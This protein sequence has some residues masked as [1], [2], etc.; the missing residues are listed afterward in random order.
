MENAIRI[1]EPTLAA[2]CLPGLETLEAGQYWLAEHALVPQ[3]ERAVRLVARGV[4]LTPMKMARGGGLRW[5]SFE[6]MLDEGAVKSALG[7]GLANSLRRLFLD[8]YGPNYRHEISHGAAEPSERREAALLAAF[9][10]LSV[11]LRLASTRFP[12]TPDA[13][14][15]DRDQ[16]QESG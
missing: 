13:S 4:G 7:P 16:G 1:V 10:I 3:L 6:E 5:A 15:P 11:A 2:A 8:P 14:K 9:G 12:D